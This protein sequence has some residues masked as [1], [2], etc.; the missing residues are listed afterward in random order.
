MHCRLETHFS[1]VFIRICEDGCF[2]CKQA[3]TKRRLNNELLSLNAEWKFYEKERKFVQKWCHENKDRSRKNVSWL[4]VMV[5][6]NFVVSALV[7]CEQWF[8]QAGR[9]AAMGKKP[10]RATVCF[11]IEHARPRDDYEY[12]TTRRQRELQQNNWFNKQNNNFCTCIT[13]LFLHFF[14]MFARLRREDA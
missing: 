4:T 10:L 12:P 14:A 7:P 11:S 13:L 3:D 9:Y 8:L 2:T 6:D 1:S 5:N